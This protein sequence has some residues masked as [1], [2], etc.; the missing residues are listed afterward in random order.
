[1]TAG[2]TAPGQDGQQCEDCQCGVVFVMSCSITFRI[3]QKR[4]SSKS[5]ALMPIK[6]TIRSA[7]TVNEQVVAQKLSGAPQDD[8]FT[9]AQMPT[10][11]G[12]DD[13]GVE[14]DGRQDGSA[15]AP[16]P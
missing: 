1:M 5:I 15:L 12:N 3:I 11:Q 9:P 7:E 6:G 14:D 2:Y 10:D 13:Q 8:Y 4:P 16:G